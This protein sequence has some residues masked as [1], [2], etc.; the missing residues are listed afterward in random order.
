MQK[1]AEESATLKRP[2]GGGGR[3]V[4]C[5]DTNGATG[6]GGSEGPGAGRRGE[7]WEWRMLKSTYRDEKTLHRIIIDYH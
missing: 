5:S 6:M 7:E 3:A 4:T 2:A 1:A